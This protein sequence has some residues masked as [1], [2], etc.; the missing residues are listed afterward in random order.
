MICTIY[1]HNMGFDRVQEMIQ[2]YFSKADLTISKQDG[3]SIAEI[4]IKGGFLSSAKK[5][6]ITYRERRKPSCQFPEVDDSPLTENLKG[7]YNYVFSLPTTNEKVKGFF[8]KK[9]QTLNCEFSVLQEGGEI[10]EL[11]AFIQHLATE[12]DAVL[13]VQ[14]GTLISKSDGQHFLDKNLNLIIDHQGNCE[15]A[16]LDVQIDSVYFSNVTDQLTDDQK[17]R[18]SKNEEIIGK[19]NIKIL[20][21]LPCVESE[22]ETTIREAKEIAQRV[23]VLA[24]TNYVAF[25]GIS[26]KQATDYLKKYNLWD[27]VTENEKDF[28]ADPT[29]EKKMNETWKCECL[30]VLLWAIYKADELPFPDDMCDLKNIAS[31]NYPLGYEDPNDYI[32]SITSARPKNEI[33]DANDLYYRLDWACVDARINGQQMDEV[34]SGVVYER[35]YALNWLVNYMEQDWDNISCDT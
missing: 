10:T 3:S 13:F 4:E 26:G 35:H 31:E 24:I 28:L 6:R 18:K 5:I 32:N 14:P 25:N 30:W 29:D 11:K 7:L 1:S 23:C 20:Q 16:D 34:N 27:H 8:L 15:I 17:E 9:M 21:S 19:K 2:N 22:E 12:F 33:L